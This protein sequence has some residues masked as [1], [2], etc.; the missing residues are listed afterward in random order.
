MELGIPELTGGGAVGL[1]TILVWQLI[2]L[3][4]KI[5]LYLDGTVEHRESMEKKI[6]ELIA[7]VRTLGAPRFAESSRPSKPQPEMRAQ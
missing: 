1:G 4:G 3:I 2:R 5:Q 7:A 6:D